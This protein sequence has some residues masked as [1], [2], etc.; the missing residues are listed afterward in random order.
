ML[1]IWFFKTIK[2]NFKAALFL[3]THS[4]AQWLPLK[5]KVVGC[6][7]SRAPCSLRC[8]QLALVLHRAIVS[9][10][11]PVIVMPST[12]VVAGPHSNFCL[13]KP[14]E[15]YMLP[16]IYQNCFFF[17]A[18]IRSQIFKEVF[19]YEVFMK[20]WET[21]VGLLS[22]NMTKFYLLYSKCIYFQLDISLSSLKETCFL[23]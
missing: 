20:L 8:D 5:R 3:L 2:L 21:N 14:H 17:L 16:S 10:F 15:K 13:W 12:P 9:W 18:L 4:G 7:S 22:I 19:L 23:V 1:P 11:P 6:F